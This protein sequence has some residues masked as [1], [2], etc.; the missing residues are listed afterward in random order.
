MTRMSNVSVRSL[1]VKRS[2]DIQDAL[3]C[4]RKGEVIIF[5]SEEKN[6][7]SAA[8]KQTDKEH[9]RQT[10][11]VFYCMECLL[12]C[13]NYKQVGETHTHARTHTHACTYVRAHTHT[14]THTHTYTQARASIHIHIHA[15]A[16]SYILLHAHMY[17]HTHA[18]TF[19][20]AAR[21]HTHTHTARQTKNVSRP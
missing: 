19:V 16:R 6:G 14:H 17:A 7:S 11:S 9:G 8:A 5:R 21:A 18:C 12:C 4:W 10:T 15:R 3:S 20:C 2:G 1:S 13:A